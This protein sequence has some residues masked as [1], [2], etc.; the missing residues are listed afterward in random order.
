MGWPR[1]IEPR[2]ITDQQGPNQRLRVDVG[3]THFFKGEHFRTFRELNLA[4]S[5]SITIKAVVPLNII[6]F[7]LKVELTAG[8]IK[9]ETLVGGTPA[10]T[11]SEN[12]PRFPCN[13]MSEVPSPAPTPQVVLTAGGTLGGSPILLDVLLCQAAGQGNQSASVGANTEDERGVGANTYHFRITASGNENAIGV[14]RARWE[15]RP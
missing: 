9:V 4:P 11:F 3:Q 8:S 7:L 15:E 13:T 5:A 10:G 12:L 1:T 14:F 6:L 2:L